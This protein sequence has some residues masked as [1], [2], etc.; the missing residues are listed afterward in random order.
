MP[1]RRDLGNAGGS[2]CLRRC[3][4][5]SA[6]PSHSEVSGGAFDAAFDLVEALGELGQLLGDL[7]LD[8]A[9][10][11]LGRRAT[12][13]D[14]VL[15]R[16]LGVL[17]AHL[18]GLDEIVDELFGVLLRHFAELRAR[19]EQTLE[20]WGIC[21]D[22]TLL[23][24]APSSIRT[25]ATA[26]RSEPIKSGVG[27]HDRAGGGHTGLDV[28][29]ATA[30]CRR[31]QTIGRGPVADHHGA[32]PRLVRPIVARTSAA[33]GSCGLP[34]T[35]AATPDAVTIDARIAPPPGIGPSGVG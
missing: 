22:D 16:L 18:A 35:I 14:E 32:L 24:V 4:L 27:H 30:E 3:L 17:A 7:G 21:H 12:A 8:H 5:G 23:P 13:F 1:S 10:E 29:I 19:I 2:G 31:H 9:D 6:P 33:I 20:E 25:F 34:A 26:A 15:H 28:C 11:S